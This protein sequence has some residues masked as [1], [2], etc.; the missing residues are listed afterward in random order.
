MTTFE[1][2]ARAF[3]AEYGHNDEM[4]FKARMRRNRFMAAWASA[5]NG[6]T[7][8][9]GKAFV[10]KLIQEDIQEAGDEIVVRTVMQH[11]GEKVNETTIRRKL[12]DF[13][14]EAKDEIMSE[15]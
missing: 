10:R 7:A 3:E 8:E 2:R 15:T 5:I 6:D 4:K 14:L 13:M 12:Q 9:D 1:D 11:V